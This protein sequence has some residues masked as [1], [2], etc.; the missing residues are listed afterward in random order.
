MVGDFFRK[1]KALKPSSRRPAKEL[2]SECGLCDTYYVHYVKEA[3]AFIHQ[4]IGE[5]EEETH[6]RS[7]HLENP[8]ELYFGVHQ[9]MMAARKIQPIEGAQWTGIVSSIACEM[10]KCCSSDQRESCLRFATRNYHRFCTAHTNHQ[11]TFP[12]HWLRSASVGF[13]SPTVT[14][15]KHQRAEEISKPCRSVGDLI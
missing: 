15:S 11:W 3:C 2:C 13:A 6:K 4:Q 8:D 5:L 12:K 10:M 14:I 7:R 1:A 9:D